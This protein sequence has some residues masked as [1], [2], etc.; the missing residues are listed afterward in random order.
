MIPQDREFREA[1]AALRHWTKAWAAA[2]KGSADK[3]QALRQCIRLEA[4]VDAL[5]ADD[6][7]QGSLL[8][9]EGQR[10][11]DDRWRCPLHTRSPVTQQADVAPWLVEP[12]R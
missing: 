10:G 9:V 7:A 6:G 5:L 4:R 3:Q 12:K 2:P 1:V 11:I 8:E